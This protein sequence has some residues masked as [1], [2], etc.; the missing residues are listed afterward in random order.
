EPVVESMARAMVAKHPDRYD[1]RKGGLGEAMSQRLS[2]FRG[3][4]F[5]RARVAPPDSFDHFPVP[6]SVRDRVLDVLACDR[7]NI[8]IRLVIKHPLERVSLLRHLREQISQPGVLTLQ[9]RNPFLGRTV[10]VRHDWTSPCVG[11]L[12]PTI[13]SFGGVKSAR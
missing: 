7:G 2:K 12:Y 3:D 4:G 6:R 8:L 11:G 13:H 1:T 5:G 10:G 9:G